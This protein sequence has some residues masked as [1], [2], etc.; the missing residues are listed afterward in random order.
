MNGSVLKIGKMNDDL[1]QIDIAS[2]VPGSYF[3]ALFDQNDSP[4]G[5]SRF[6]KD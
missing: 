5:S 4:V 2:L 3:I 6:V 1:Q